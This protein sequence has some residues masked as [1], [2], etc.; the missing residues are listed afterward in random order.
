VKIFGDRAPRPPQAQR[1]ATA[2]TELGGRLIHEG[3]AVVCV[4]AHAGTTVHVG[5]DPI[6]TSTSC[7]SLDFG[8]GVHR[9]P[10]QRRA[11]IIVKSAVERDL[12]LPAL[13]LALPAE[14]LAFGPSLWA[15]STP[16]L[17]VMF[18]PAVEADEMD[19]AGLGSVHFAASAGDVAWVQ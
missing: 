17:P 10:A 12:R 2:D 8:A 6:W 16:T 1:F 4:G 18:D 15:R 13:K 14:Q 5:T 3:E 19:R 7:A 9:C 11:C